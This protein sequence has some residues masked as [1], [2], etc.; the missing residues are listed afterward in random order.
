[1]VASAVAAAVQ[2]V[3]RGIRSALGYHAVDGDHSKRQIAE[4]H[5]GSEDD[6]L[7]RHKRK[8]LVAQSRDIERNIA[9]YGWAIRKHLDYVTTFRFLPKSGDKGLDRKIGDFVT[10]KWS[11]PENFDVAGINSSEDFLRLFEMRRLVDGD[12]G[13]LRLR[14][15]HT[16]AIEGDRVAN[17]TSE[18]DILQGTPEAP[19]RWVQGVEITPYGRHLNYAI[20]KR[21]SAGLF[22]N[23]TEFET[24][25]SANDMTLFA[26]RN[27]F[28]QTRGISPMAPAVNSLIDIYEGM[29][30]ALQKM[31]LS[32]LMAMAIF[33]GDINIKQDQ[34]GTYDK[35]KFGRGIKIIPL[36]PGERA[37]ILESRTPSQEMQ[38]YVELQIQFGLKAIDI[39]YSFFKENF[40]NYSGSRQALV[41]YSESAR[42]RRRSIVRVLNQLTRWRIA[43]AVIDREL[44]PAALGAYWR[45]QPAG[46]PWIDPEKEAKANTAAL[47][48]GTTSRTRI[49]AQQGDDLEE[50]FEELAAEQKLADQYGIKLSTATAAKAIA[51][52]DPKAKREPTDGQQQPDED[53]D[54]ETDE[55]QS[56]DESN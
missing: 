9:L 17:P 13:V 2:L 45:W 25:V 42:N 1:M 38:N 3:G 29:D 47:A 27:R 20:H 33:K 7:P 36:Q 48:N 53:P 43:L 26:Y 23:S 6:V 24:V 16:Q 41:M 52:P 18:M 55:E 10:E 11:A 15:G 8:E 30:Y 28:D 51:E 31:K 56:D 14:T 35:L 44:P 12:C 46:V 50:I 54:D 4:P 21:A 19:R 5:S 34:Y 37:E 22:G 39:P 49:A 40:S 32:Q